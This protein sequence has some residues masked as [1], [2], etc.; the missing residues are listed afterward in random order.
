MKDMDRNQILCVFY[1]RVKF[2]FHIFYSTHLNVINFADS[3][4]LRRFFELFTI[5]IKDY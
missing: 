5:N 4:D 2:D 3:P 1:S